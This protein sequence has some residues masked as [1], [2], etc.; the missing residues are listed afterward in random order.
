MGGLHIVSRSRVDRYPSISI[1]FSAYSV[2]SVCKISTAY[3]DEEL[4]GS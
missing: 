4:C 3:Q 1:T 2:Y